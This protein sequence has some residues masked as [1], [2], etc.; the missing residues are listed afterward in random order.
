MKYK[1]QQQI[2][3]CCRLSVRLLQVDLQFQRAV[4][5]A[6]GVLVDDDIGNA[7]CDAVGHNPVVNAPADVLLPRSAHI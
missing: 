6:H 2:M 7:V 3:L 1:K 4:V 5:A